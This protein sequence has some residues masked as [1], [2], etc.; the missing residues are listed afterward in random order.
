MVKTT[1]KIVMSETENGMPTN[2]TSMNACVDLF[3]TIGAMRGSDQPRI[4]NK[5]NSAY[6]E[7]QLTALKLLFWSRDVRGGAGERDIFRKFWADLV[8]NHTE[9]AI[10][11]MPLVPIYGRWDDLW[12]DS[13]GLNE[14]YDKQLLKFLKENLWFAPFLVVLLHL[15]LYL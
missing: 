3:G 10:K 8:V 7:H 4:V 13:Y 5:F 1:K 12:R 9:L 15:I 2:P 14:E 11:L 6:A